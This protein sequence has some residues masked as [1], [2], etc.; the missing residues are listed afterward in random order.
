M[1]QLWRES[2]SAS[3][4]TALSKASTAKAQLAY[5]ESASGVGFVHAERSPAT[6]FISLF[7]GKYQAEFSS[8]VS[9]L[10]CDAFARGVEAVLSHM[11]ASDDV[12]SA[13]E[14]AAE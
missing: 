11:T 4:P 7:D 9:H 1:G 12:N 6:R 5:F 14:E 2:V 13:S 8:R 10:E 3:Y